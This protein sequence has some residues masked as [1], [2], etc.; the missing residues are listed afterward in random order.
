MILASRCLLVLTSHN[1]LSPEQARAAA[2][3]FERGVERF[4][5]VKLTQSEFDCLVS[6]SFN[7][8]LGTFQ[9]S[10]LRQ[11][12]LRGD[13]ITA[14]QSLLKYNKA[15]GKVLKGLDNRRKDEAAL[16]NKQG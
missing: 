11:A 15:G 12:L 16:F 6:F 13:K 5:P 14:I 10:T 2:Q 8:G 1:T 9:R 4:V 7:L 3:L